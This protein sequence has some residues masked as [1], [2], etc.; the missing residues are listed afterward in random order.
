[1]TKVKHVKARKDYPEFGIAKGEMYYVWVPGF[2]A[3]TRRSKTKPKQS[4]LYLGYRSQAYELQERLDDFENPGNLT[5]MAG[6]VEELIGDAE[7]L[8]DEV[9]DSLDAMPEGLQQGDTGQQLQE[10]IEALEAFIDEILRIEYTSEL[11]DG[12]SPEELEEEI[13][14]KFEELKAVSLEIS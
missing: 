7:S 8:R 9:Q 11:D 5:E 13:E 14:A 4:Q 10:R 2:R 1:M 12:A 3:Q 6:F